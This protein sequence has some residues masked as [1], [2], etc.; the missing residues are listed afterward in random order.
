MTIKKS[1][2]GAMKKYGV[3][4]S[5]EGNIL[6]LRKKFMADRELI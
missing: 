3:N 4:F 5:R 1:P 6:G 2:A